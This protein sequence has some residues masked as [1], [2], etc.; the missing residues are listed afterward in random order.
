MAYFNLLASVPE[1][2]VE[3]LRRDWSA[4]LRP[5]LV[6]GA[7]HLLAYWVQVQ[8]L[9]GLLRRALDGGEPIHAELWHPLR[10][11]LFHRP[12]AV[13]ELA[14]QIDAAWAEALRVTPLPNGDD[15]TAAEMGRLLRLFRHAAGAGECVVS[16]LD[17]PADQERARRVRPLWPAQWDGPERSGAT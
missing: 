8:P 10:P 11:P 9:G 2:D 16:A 4:L 7:S 1:S 5:S 6:L 13:R 12:A 14:P 15:W 3:R 17:A